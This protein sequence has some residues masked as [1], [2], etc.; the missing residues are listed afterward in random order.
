MRRY[1]DRLARQYLML[2]ESEERVAKMTNEFVAGWH[3]EGP[4]SD[5]PSI[6]ADPKAGSPGEASATNLLR[7]H[8]CSRTT[9]RR[10]SNGDVAHTKAS[11]RMAAGNGPARAGWRVM[12]SRFDDPIEPRRAARLRMSARRPTR[13]S[14]PYREARGSAPSRPQTQIAI[15]RPVAS[16]GTVAGRL[17]PCP[18]AKRRADRQAA[19]ASRMSSI[20]SPCAR[21]DFS[22]ASAAWRR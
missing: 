6:Q 19:R 7:R 10:S 11:K 20:G 9:R 2:A 16:S 13:G 22:I 15:G 1:F 4:I 5:S 21:P 3:H 18:A 14:N 8:L 17:R 12:A